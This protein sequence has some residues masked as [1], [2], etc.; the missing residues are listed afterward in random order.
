MKN[1]SRARDF[2]LASSPAV[3]RSRRHGRPRSSLPKLL[4]LPA[5]SSSSSRQLARS[6]E[7]RGGG[8][9]V[10][11]WPYRLEQLDQ[12]VSSATC[13]GS[14]G[15]PE[16]SP[17][18]QRWQSSRPAAAALNHSPREAAGGTALPPSWRSTEEEAQGRMIWLVDELHLGVR[19]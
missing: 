6:C 10:A 9:R 19:G 2:L 12:V 4:A 11:T 7:L 1:F 16:Q 14:P 3:T 13:P 8:G 15:R 5:R 17:R 18:R